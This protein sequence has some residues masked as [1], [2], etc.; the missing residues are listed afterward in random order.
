MTVSE[1]M[2]RISQLREI[3][4]DIDGYELS[5]NRT[6]GYSDEVLAVD[7]DPSDRVL[8]LMEEAQ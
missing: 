8:L 7:V 2:E 4:P 5:V 6:I 3:A 1:L